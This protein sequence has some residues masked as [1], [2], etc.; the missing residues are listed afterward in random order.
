MM[1]GRI[2]DEFSL[3]DIVRVIRILRDANTRSP[4][5][6][7]T[8]CGEP[9]QVDNDIFPMANAGYL[10]IIPRA[11]KTVSVPSSYPLDNTSE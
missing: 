10:A 8:G 4:V 5:Q 3:L 11:M 2:D 9:L 6:L 1:N 7:V